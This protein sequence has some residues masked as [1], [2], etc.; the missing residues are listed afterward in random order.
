[1]NAG[2]TLNNLVQQI[3]IKLIP[4]IPKLVPTEFLPSL[5]EIDGTKKHLGKLGPMS[6][7]SERLGGLA[8]GSLIFRSGPAT[9]S[10]FTLFPSLAI[11][12]YARI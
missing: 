11:H 8:G 1:M 12:F 9:P 2:I 3:I 7:I 5:Y 6:V 4:G 10:P